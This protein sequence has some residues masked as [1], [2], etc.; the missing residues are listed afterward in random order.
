MQF[1]RR[2]RKRFILS[3]PSTDVLLGAQPSLHMHLYS[4]TSCL[5]SG[6][7][8][9]HV[10]YRLGFLVCIH[11]N[12]KMHW[13]LTYWAYSQMRVKGVYLCWKICPFGLPKLGVTVKKMLKLEPVC[14]QETSRFEKVGSSRAAKIKHQVQKKCATLQ[15]CSVVFLLANSH[16]GLTTSAYANKH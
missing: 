4:H 10:I 2:I 14:W 7:S 8:Q 3:Q 12:S 15:S 16:L 1:H 5:S 6:R 13:T 11:V 9:S